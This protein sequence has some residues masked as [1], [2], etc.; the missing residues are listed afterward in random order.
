MLFKHV[1][2]YKKKFTKEIVETTETRALPVGSVKARE[3]VDDFTRFFETATGGQLPEVGALGSKIFKDHRVVARAALTVVCLGNRYGEAGP[4][5]AIEGDLVASQAEQGSK[6]SR[7]EIG[8]AGFDEEGAR[9]PVRGISILVRDFQAG[10]VGRAVVN[11]LDAGTFNLLGAKS[12][13]LR[14]ILASN[15]T[16]QH[17]S[18]T[19]QL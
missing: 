18:A 4:D 10:P 8:R 6:K 15:H 9:G 2:S 3:S 12:K 11:S 19:C 17:V 16:L 14:R 1:S 13:C 5:I 7:R